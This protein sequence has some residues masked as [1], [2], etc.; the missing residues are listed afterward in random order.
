MLFTNWIG[1][2]IHF[3]SSTRIIAMFAT[4]VKVE[5]VFQMMYYDVQLIC[6]VANY[7]QL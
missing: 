5:D 1:K 4:T 3:L 2:I 7:I 6:Y